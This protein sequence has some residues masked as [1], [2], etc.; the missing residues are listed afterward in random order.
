[1]SG[2]SIAADVPRVQGALTIFTAASLTDAFR[3]MAAEIEQ[4]NPGTKLSF[5]FAGSP[6]LRAQLAQGA[7]AD[8]FASA[9]EP[10]MAGAAQD[11]TVTGE[12]Q[13]FARNLR[14]PTGGAYLACRAG[15][16]VL[17]QHDETR[18]P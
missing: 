17:A 15:P 5:N 4:A 9:D 12:P 6:T 2:G 11:G 10:N 16:G 14:D 3:A 13:I 18:H 8:V 7:R 1:M